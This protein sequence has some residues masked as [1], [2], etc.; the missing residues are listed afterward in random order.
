[1]TAKQRFDHATVKA[2][3]DE[4][5]FLVDCPIVAR[6][7][8]QVYSTPHGE[9]REFRPA[10]E[11]FKA[12]ALDSYAGKPITLGHVMVTPG[13]A[14]NVVVGACAGSGIR[15]GAGVKVP[16]SIYSESAIISAK[17]RKTAEISVGYTTIDIEKSGWGCNDTGEY[18]FDEDIKQ[19]QEI[20]DSWVRFDA[21]QTNIA[22]NHVALVFRGRAGVAKLNLDS[23][24]EFPYYTSDGK[25]KEDSFMTVKIKLD[26]D[27]E[28]DIP[29][30][31]AEHIESIKADASKE[32]AKADAIEAERD[33]LKVKVDGI[34]SMIDA[35]IKKAK[36]DAE[37]RAELEK[38]ADEVG[39]KC[40]GLT[41]KEVKIAYVKSVSGLDVAA[42]EDAY[43]NAAFDF[44]RSSD[45]MAAQR[46][47]INGN[48]SVKK[49]SE[50]EKPLNPNA[51]LNK[52]K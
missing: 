1:M 14:S 39:I 47:A 5:G 20:P 49:D 10:S 26:G 33:A 3:F 52:I 41:D 30:Q 15:D 32:K 28:F 17:K 43:I 50:E 36:E 37:K 7:G 38:T 2:R 35:A 29:K 9:R 12:D 46:M 34:P 25:H 51:R 4:N 42:K 16:V 27:Q 44:A 21:V 31:V 6:I 18:I 19:D 40:D 48:G 13:N 8:L 23:M 24:Q 11:V 22:V 45:K